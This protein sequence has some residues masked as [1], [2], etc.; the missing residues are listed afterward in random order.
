MQ[1]RKGDLWSGFCISHRPT[2]G[3][4]CLKINQQIIFERGILLQ[5]VSFKRDKSIGNFAVRSALLSDNQPGTF[6]CTR[7]RFKACPLIKNGNRILGVKQPINI[8]DRFTCVATKVIYC[9]IYAKNLH[10]RET[11]NNASANIFVTLKTWQMCFQTSCV[12]FQPPDPFYQQKWQFAFPS[13]PKSSNK[14][15]SVNSAI[16]TLTNPVNTS[17]LTNSPRK[18]S[19]SR[20]QS[21]S[22]KQNA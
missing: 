17:S 3:S 22:N 7:S 9:I 2:S 15:S 18:K 8:S 1:E 13:F 11:E 21:V 16:L 6:K 10:K 19:T 5:L 4:L 20:K 12:P 14:S